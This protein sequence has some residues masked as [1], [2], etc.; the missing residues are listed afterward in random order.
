MNVWHHSRSRLAIGAALAIAC[1]CALVSGAAAVTIA[2]GSYQA[3]SVGETVSIPIVLDSASGGLSGYQITVSLSDTSIATITAVEFPAWATLKSSSALPSGQVVL[4][5]ADLSQQ[6]PLGG[7]GV[8]LA[9]MT[10]KATASGSTTITIIPDPI[11]GVQN[12]NGDLYSLSTPPGTLTVGGTSPGTGPT[13]IP[14]TIP[15]VE[16]PTVI[17]PTP[18]M[19]GP[20]IT[21]TPP[22]DGSGSVPTSSPVYV[23]PVETIPT[24]VPA[25]VS[26]G[27]PT[28]ISAPTVI[29]PGVQPAFG[30]GKRYAIGNP[31]TY[32]GTR[33]AAGGTAANTTGSR[34]VAGPV[35]TLKPGSRA[36]GITPP[37][38]RFVR[39]YPAARW[40]AGMK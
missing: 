5:A 15:T 39:W 23:Y 25:V 35:A 22:S 27:N 33:F 7:A 19:G 20:V 30:V 24:S 6:V 36:Y 28:D 16:V 40:A 17:P 14:P 3:G 2:T 13:P 9:T 21:L 12:R 10:V 11:L 26:P 32:I 38:G 34:T 29:A 31:G 4:K 1:L 8:T 37:A 18:I